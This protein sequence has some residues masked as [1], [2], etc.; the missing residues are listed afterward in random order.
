MSQTIVSPRIRIDL[1]KMSFTFSESSV[2]NSL[3]PKMKTY[4]YVCGF[5]V[6]LRKTLIDKKKEE[7][8]NRVQG[9]F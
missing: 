2:W 1:Y 5:K 8:R 9:N 6:G 7:K 4:K 3:P